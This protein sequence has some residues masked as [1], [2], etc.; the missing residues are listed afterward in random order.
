MFDETPPLWRPYGPGRGGGGTKHE[1]R[2][3]RRRGGLLMFKYMHGQ[4]VV[5][6]SIPSL[7]E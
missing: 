5:I 7:C 3:S 6:V 2:P 1:M 4:G